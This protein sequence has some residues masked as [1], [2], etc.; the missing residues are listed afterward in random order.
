MFNCAVH[1]EIYACGKGTDGQL[2]LGERESRKWPVV[3]ERMRGYPVIAIAAGDSHSLFLTLSGY[4][5]ACGSNKVH[6]R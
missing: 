6:W 4:V 2:G 3:V 1:G 5:F